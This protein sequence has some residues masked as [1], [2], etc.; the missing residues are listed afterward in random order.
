MRTIELYALCTSNS[1][2]QKQVEFNSASLDKPS[3]HEKF[4]SAILSN[5]FVWINHFVS[6]F[7]SLAYRSILLS[8][9]SFVEWKTNDEF[10]LCVRTLSD[11][12]KYFISFWDLSTMIKS[13]YENIHKKCRHDLL[14]DA[15]GQ[16]HTKEVS[17]IFSTSEGTL[18]GERGW[19]SLNCFWG[20]NSSSLRVAARISW[21]ISEGGRWEWMKGWSDVWKKKISN[22]IVASYEFDP[23]R[24]AEKGSE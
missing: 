17:S 20:S 4:D 21:A 1:N 22:V 19:G 24:W 10:V 7:Y 8:G 14:S 15:N 11:S 18:F 23:F 2:L 13:R 12:W 16:S 3:D 5:F 6:Y 9:S